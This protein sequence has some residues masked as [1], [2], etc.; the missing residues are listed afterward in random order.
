MN[1]E[2][3][4]SLIDYIGNRSIPGLGFNMSYWHGHLDR[5]D[6]PPIF[7]GYEG[8]ERVTDRSGH[9]CGTVACLAGWNYAKR[10]SHRALEK[11]TD[12]FFSS[13]EWR[14][15]ADY[16]GLTYEQGKALFMPD[17][18]FRNRI[19][20]DQALR[21]LCNLM[22]TGEVNWTRAMAEVPAPQPKSP[23]EA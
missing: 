1:R 8:A 23:A 3:I 21:C 19:T 9:A 12:G 11:A 13:F 18:S 15:E 6:A 5:R 17:M 20:L 4:Q 2:R 10:T 22:E 14:D 7:Y 16:L